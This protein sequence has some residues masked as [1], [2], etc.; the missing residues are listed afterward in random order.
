[1]NIEGLRSRISGDVVAPEDPDW[2]EARVAWNLA[3][4][5]RPALVALPESA[6]T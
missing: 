2:N 3:V 4:D 5:Q 1:V 6:T